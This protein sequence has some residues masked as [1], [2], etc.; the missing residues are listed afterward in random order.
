MLTQKTRYALR[1][2]L[3]VAAQPVT[4]PVLVA[5]IASSQK[6]PR[7]FLEAIMLDLKE[8]GFLSSQRGRGGGY[9]LAR[10]ASLI[11]FGDIIRA[12]E[13]P[14]ALLPCASVNFYQKCLDCEDEASC[15]IRKAMLVVREDTART[16]E[17]ISLADATARKA[18]LVD[19]KFNST[20]L[21]DI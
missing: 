6:L 10:D 9:K 2:L 19:N 12:M 20:C 4:E 21:V 5:D 8:A 13:G 7:K 16:L 17:G 3:H 18:V 1:A 14:L 15:A 11:S